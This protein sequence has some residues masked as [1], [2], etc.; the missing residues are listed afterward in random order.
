MRGWFADERRDSDFWKGFPLVFAYKYFK[1]KEQQFFQESDL[2]ISLTEAG[3][4]EIIRLGY[5]AA[6]NIAV[7]PTCVDLELFK[8]FDM[9]TR[10]EVRSKLDLQ[11][12]EKVLVYSGTIEGN[13]REQ[14]I[15]DVL[16]AFRR[17]YPEG[18]L[19]LLTTTDLDYVHE[20]MKRNQVETSWVRIVQVPF[21]EVGKH[22]MASDLGLIMYDQAFSVIGR[23][24]T[25]LGEYWASGIPAL[26]YGKYGDITLLHDTYEGGLQLFRDFS[27]DAYEVAIRRYKERD[28]DTHSLRKY[29]EDYYDVEVGVSKLHTL[30]RK[31]LG[32]G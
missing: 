16:H 29:A 31:L 2:T 30:Y 28:I 5:K 19:L 13:A 23:S 21:V 20:V 32:N 26:S 17:V 24:P 3:K 12:D 9:E 11:M 14:T 4:Q 27:V 7:I 25:K 1:W 22:L 10:Q 8:P 18:K 6:E 15:F